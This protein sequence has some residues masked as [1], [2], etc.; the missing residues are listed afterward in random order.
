MSE[1]ENFLKDMIN[2][3]SVRWATDGKTEI[4]RI[5]DPVVPKQEFFCLTFNDSLKLE[6]ILKRV[7]E[8]GLRS[9][10]LEEAKAILES[11]DRPKVEEWPHSYN[12]VLIRP[13]D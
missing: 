6:E 13:K 12:F 11:R 5:L 3:P 9:A 4:T 8:L 7:D 1:S 2:D 10:T